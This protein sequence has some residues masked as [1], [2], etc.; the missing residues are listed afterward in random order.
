MFAAEHNKHA[1]FNVLMDFFYT[2]RN[3]ALHD[4]HFGHK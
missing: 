2:T 1:W 3:G 4:D